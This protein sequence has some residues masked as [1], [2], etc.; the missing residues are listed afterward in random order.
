MIGTVGGQIVEPIQG[1]PGQVLACL[2]LLTPETAGDHPV[3]S[4]IGKSGILNFRDFEFLE[5]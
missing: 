5:L 2:N 3:P 1:G 4:Q